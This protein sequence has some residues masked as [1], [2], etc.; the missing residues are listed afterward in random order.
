MARIIAAA[1]VVAA[2]FG[3]PPAHNLG[4]IA[5]ATALALAAFIPGE[6]YELV[7][8]G[9]LTCGALWSLL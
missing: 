9:A 4:A 7:L 3:P 2:W 6:R 5:V 8:D 1:G